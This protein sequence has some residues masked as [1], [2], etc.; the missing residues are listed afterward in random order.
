MD[1]IPLK[2]FLF[3]SVILISSGPIVMGGE[4]GN[5]KPLKQ[6]NDKNIVLEMNET[7][8]PLDLKWLI[9]E[10][11]AHNP[12]IIAAQKRL[13]AAKMKIPQAKSLDDPSIRAGSY[14]MSNNPININ[15]IGRAHV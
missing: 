3:L 4:K 12:E 5:S 10:A 11:M 9:E 13:N 15:E 14:D 8:A 1:R 7:D 2:Q 6:T